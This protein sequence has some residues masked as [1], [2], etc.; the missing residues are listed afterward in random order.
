MPS[1]A[2][3]S[4]ALDSSTIWNTRKYTPWYPRRDLRHAII[5][6]GIIQIQFNTKSVLDV[7]L[8]WCPPFFVIIKN[9]ITSTFRRFF[10]FKL[11]ENSQSI[12][13]SKTKTFIQHF[14][15]IEVNEGCTILAAGWS[16]CICLRIV[17]PSLVMVTSPFPSWI[18]REQK[19]SF[20]AQKTQLLIHSQVKWSIKLSYYMMRFISMKNSTILSMPLG[21]RLVLMAS[22][23]AVNQNTRSNINHYTCCHI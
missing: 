4:W 21:P 19:H 1:P 12:T 2:S 10:L 20:S 6:V 13:K 15:L 16:T 11:V 3:I 22:A 8:Y 9:D 18:C 23:T 17:A 5:W 14:Q 7:L